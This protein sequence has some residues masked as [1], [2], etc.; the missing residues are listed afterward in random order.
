MYYSYMSFN[1]SYLQKLLRELNFKI[2]Q[3]TYAFLN[4][5]VFFA[6]NHNFDEDSHSSIELEMTFLTIKFVYTR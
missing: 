6:I 2:I 5:E 4:P 3:K 1:K